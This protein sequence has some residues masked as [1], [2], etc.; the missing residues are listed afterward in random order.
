MICVLGFPSHSVHD[1]H[2]T[3]DFLRFYYFFFLCCF[4]TCT[5]VSALS[6]SF[7][8]SFFLFFPLQWLPFR[9]KCVARNNAHTH[10]WHKI[11][12]T[13]KT[14]RKHR[15]NLHITLQSSLC[16]S[17][18]RNFTH[19]RILRLNQSYSSRFW[20]FIVVFT[21]VHVRIYSFGVCVFVRSFA[22]A[23]GMRAVK[24]HRNWFNG[25]RKAKKRTRSR[26]HEHHSS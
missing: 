26:N 20:L 5:L 17:P 1:I 24:V 19:L 16:A 3:Y 14:M 4:R 21:L 11:I 9:L 13:Q 23:F 6:C 10:T 25:I 2:V 7:L 22:L 18:H 15:T 12:D 8:S